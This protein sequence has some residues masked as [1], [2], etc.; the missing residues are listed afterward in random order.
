M[1]LFIP[2]LIRRNLS[3]DWVDPMI[4]ELPLARP[5]EYTT[6]DKYR[7]KYV[8]EISR[9]ASCCDLAGLLSLRDTP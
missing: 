7:Y 5:G 6:V 8:A 2:S 9:N 3:A 1:K 4:P